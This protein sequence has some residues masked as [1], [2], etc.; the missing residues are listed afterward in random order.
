[1]LAVQVP[2]AS[3]ASDVSVLL[4]GT[5]DVTHLTPLTSLA[6]STGAL[7]DAL[8]GLGGPVVMCSVPEFRAMTALLRSLMEVAN[9]YGLLVRMVQRRSALAR[10]DVHLVDVRAAVGP[11]FRRSGT[12]MSAD[13]FHPSAAG[14]GRI[15]D[16]V[17]PTITSV[18]FH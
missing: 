15:A 4:V 6:R 16:A 1:M 11:E 13:S 17:A 2:L 14:Y 3:R 8:A 10:P 9:G 18:L 12:T 5:N 7:L